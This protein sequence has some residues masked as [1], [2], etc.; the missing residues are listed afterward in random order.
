MD[1]IQIKGGRTLTGETRIQGSKNATLPI[2]ASTILIPGISVIT[3]CPRISDVETMV[4]LLSSIGCSIEW[5]ADELVIDATDVREYRLPRED[6]VRMRSSIMLMGAMLGRMGETALDYPGGCVI[7]KRPIDLHLMALRR[8]GAVVEETEQKIHAKASRLI[9]TA[10]RLPINSVG[11]TENCILGAVLAE[12]VTILSNA[13]ME[14]EITALCEFL[15]SAG[16]SIEGAGTSQITIL[17]VP[18]LHSTVYEIP[19]DRIVAGTYLFAG[20]ICGGK[21]TLRDIP[22]SHM[23]ATIRT[24]RRLHGDVRI[25]GNI[26][27]I[28]RRGKIEGIPL[29]RT[30]NYPGFPTDMQSALMVACAVASGK[31]VIEETIFENR[32]RIARE[33]CRMGAAIEIQ[34]GKA[35]IDGD[36]SLHGTQVIAEELRGGAA[37]VLAGLAADQVTNVMNR[38]FIE[39][40]YENICKDLRELGADISYR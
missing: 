8:L 36:A 30:G 32:Y 13:A 28:E 3:H 22:V 9:G 39:R 20:V 6:V 21:I 4:R 27:E 11:A 5:N 16:A 26:M 12:G 15:Q 23:S 2:L 10:V 33:L 19:G 18:Q 38:H 29:I 1:S 25:T 37:L 35:Y 34:D 7:G 40:G 17:G 14:P 31:S 24:A